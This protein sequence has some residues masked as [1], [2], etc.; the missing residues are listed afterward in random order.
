MVR[1]VDPAARVVQEEGAWWLEDP[2]GRLLLGH[3][4]LEA[5]RDLAQ[6]IALLREALPDRDRDDWQDHAARTAGETD[7]RRPKRSPA[8]P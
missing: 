3:A 1:A 2:L 7:L 4:R 6:Y 8:R 5:S